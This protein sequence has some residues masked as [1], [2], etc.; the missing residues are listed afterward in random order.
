MRR[1]FRDSRDM[2]SW[3]GSAIT[4][5]ALLSAA[6][7]IHFVGVAS[8]AAFAERAVR[9]LTFS[10]MTFSAGL[11]LGLLI[12]GG[13]WLAGGRGT[14]LGMKDT[15]LWTASLFGVVCVGLAV[16]S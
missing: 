4:S 2:E 14:N 1:L 15:A 8:N 13:A 11:A 16:L 3:S 5:A 6:A 7:A 10:A 9:A 12:W